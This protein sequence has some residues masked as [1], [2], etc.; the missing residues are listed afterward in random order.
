MFSCN[1]SALGVF[2]SRGVEKRWKVKVSQVQSSSLTVPM[3]QTYG[4]V[5]RTALIV[6]NSCFFGKQTCF[7]GKSEIGAHDETR[8]QYV[9]RRRNPKKQVV[10]RIVTV[11][12]T[13]HERGGVRA[14]F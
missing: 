6:G 8:E 1:K 12:G 4:K 3:C 10:D 14:G 7:F 2:E 11:S 9:I 5:K 13:N